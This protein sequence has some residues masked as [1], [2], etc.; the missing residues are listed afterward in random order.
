MMIM[1]TIMTILMSMIMTMLM[2]MMVMVND[3]ADYECDGENTAVTQSRWGLR[4]GS[5]WLGTRL[6]VTQGSWWMGGTSTR[7]GGTRVTQGR[8]MGGTSTSTSGRH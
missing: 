5:R 3:D 4:P 6:P 8:W 1:T 2:L 7:W